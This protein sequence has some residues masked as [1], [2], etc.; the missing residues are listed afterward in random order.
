MINKYIETI[1]LNNGDDIITPSNNVSMVF[2]D[3]SLLHAVIILNNTT[4]TTIPVLDYDK[5]FLGLISAGQIFKFLGEKHLEGFDSL[6]EYKVRDALD[7]R[8]SLI[9]EN[10]KLEDAMRALINHNF[11]IVVD[12][13]MIF[14]GLVTRS[15]LLKKVNFLAHEIDKDYKITPKA[16]KRKRALIP[17]FIR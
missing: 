17:N 3:N 11:L 13:D 16:A 4:Y 5:K 6:E 15:A 9:N 2:G 7:H 14:K 1:I 10:F 8:Y 12:E